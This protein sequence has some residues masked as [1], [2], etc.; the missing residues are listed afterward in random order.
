MDFSGD[1]YRPFPRCFI[2][3]FVSGIIPIEY[4][5]S[6]GVSMCL[7]YLCMLVGCVEK[8]LATLS[9]KIEI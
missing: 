8:G 4:D 3:G 1:T 2:M 9:L 6:F 7:V 5:G